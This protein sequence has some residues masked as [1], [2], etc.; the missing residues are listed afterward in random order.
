M[1]SKTYYCAQCR[2]D[3]P[4]RPLS[5]IRPQ[6]FGR[7]TVLRRTHKPRSPR[8]ALLRRLFSRSESRRWRIF[9]IAYTRPRYRIVRNIMPSDCKQ[10]DINFRYP[11]ERSTTT[12]GGQRGMTNSAALVYVDTVKKQNKT[13]Q[14]CEHGRYRFFSFFFFVRLFIL[15][16]LFFFF[17]LS[18][19]RFYTSDIVRAWEPRPWGGGRLISSI[20]IFTV[21][22]SCP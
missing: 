20:I 10:Y 11:S 5:L 16:V 22:P 13:K 8:I 19:W 2:R 9:R 6:P 18:E 14:L 15:L 3:T 7:F 4:D 1:K 12:S 17:F 21:S